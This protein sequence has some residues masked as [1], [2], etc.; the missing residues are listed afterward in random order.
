MKTGF[1]H[2]KKEPSPKTSGTA[3]LVNT[4]AM[5]PQFPINSENVH[6]N[7]TKIFPYF[8]INWGKKSG[9]SFVDKLTN[10]C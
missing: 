3:R 8:S 4:F 7:V 9:H 6:N 10:P 5:F 2:W 1:Y